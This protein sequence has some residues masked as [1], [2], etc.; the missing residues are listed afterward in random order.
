MVQAPIFLLLSE[1][2]KQATKDCVQEN[3]YE[4]DRV[5]IVLRLINWDYE[6][7]SLKEKGAN[8]YRRY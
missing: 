8:E 1:D 3:D 5:S 2:G 7:I 4:D 6:A